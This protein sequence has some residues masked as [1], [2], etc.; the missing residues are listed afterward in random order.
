MLAGRLKLRDIR[1]VLDD[2]LR[3]DWLEWDHSSD[4]GVVLPPGSELS[5]WEVLLHLPAPQVAPLLL[6]TRLLARNGVLLRVTEVEAY[7]GPGTDEASHAHRGRTAR[8]APM[9]AA[10]GCVYVYLSYGIHHCVNIVA[11]PPDQA[12]G[13]LLRAGTV[14]S[15]PAAHRAASGPGR[16]GRTV[17]ATLAD[18]GSTLFGGGLLRFVSGP[19]PL[20]VTEIEVGPRIGISKAVERPWRWWI[21]DDPSV[22]R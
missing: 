1:A 10:P 22:S 5:N 8:N 3:P 4:P 2:F 11:H 7:T 17:G 20:P 12:G 19:V 6:G 16:L 13:I 9:F 14:E 15:G 18:S 21:R